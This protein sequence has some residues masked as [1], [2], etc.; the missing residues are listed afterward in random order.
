MA[1]KTIYC[2]CTETFWVE[3]AERLANEHE[4]IPCYWTGLTR[5]MPP[6]K[7]IFPDVVYHDSFDAMRG[8]PASECAEMPRGCVDHE[9]LLSLSYNESIVMTM[10]NRM[11][12]GR[13]FT[14]PERVRHYHTLLGYWLGVLDYYEPD[15]VIFPYIPH[16]IYDYVLYSLCRHR[17]IKTFLL[18]V[19]PSFYNS[20]LFPVENFELESPAQIQFEKWCESD[21]TDGTNQLSDVAENYLKKMQGDYLEG[22]PF[23]VKNDRQLL[24]KILNKRTISSIRDF[25]KLYR[26]MR[27]LLISPWRAGRLNYLKHPRRRIENSKWSDFEYRFYKYK[28]NRLKK[29][30]SHHYNSLTKKID[31]DKPFIYVALH[32]QPEQ[33]SSPMGGFFVEQ[34]FMID[35]LSKTIPLGWYLYVKENY[36]QNVLLSHGERARSFDFY[37]DLASIPNVVL[38]PTSTNP[39][40]LIDNAKAV[41]T[42]TGT[43][44]W[45][46]VMRKKPALIFGYAWYR[47]CEGV[48]FVP[49]QKTLLDAIEVIQYGYKVDINKVKLFMLAI[50]SVCYKGYSDSNYGAV[51]NVT[52]KANVNNLVDAISDFFP[53]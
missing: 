18:Q 44:G 33:T 52:Y 51:A 24:N 26:S 6:I 38:V 20:L 10:M 3:A 21:Q 14:Y 11:D 23:Q 49:D 34:Y 27:S 5:D 47:G 17:K 41:A 40:D 43:S 53:N 2:G 30:M 16:V 42:V 12:P 39:W 48:F 1:I 8:V 45:E 15:I 46:A 37:D 22:M 29:K 25:K 13:A 19:P 4:M 50:E 36:W 32:Y 28:A 35:L 9:I 31:M 7:K